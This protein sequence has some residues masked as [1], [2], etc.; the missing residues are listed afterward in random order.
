ME[1]RKIL[2]SLIV[3]AVYLLNGC[4]ALQPFPNYAK[5][6][7]TISLAVG[8]PIDMTRANTTA[9]FT[10]NVDEIPVDITANIRAI[11]KLYPDPTSKV[12]QATMYTNELVSSS[13]HAPWVTIVAIDLPEGLAVGSGEIQFNTTA[14]Y[15]DITSHI[16]NLQLPV[17]IIAGTGTPNSF[18][19]ELGIGS[20]TVSDLTNLES[21]AVAVFSPAIPSVACPCPDYAA[22]EIKATI[23]TSIGALNPYFTKIVA[24]DLTVSTISERNFT[25][26][27]NGEE[28]TAMFISTT[29]KLKYFEAQFS[30]AV[31]EAFSFLGLPTI[32]SV[33]YFDLDGNE[34]SGPVA[35]YSVSLK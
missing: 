34:I 23:P 31:H 8:S 13:N 18:V 4:T 22:I 21:Q 32:N 12:Y 10:S 17:E 29:G 24:E 28:V 7:D 1:I 9:T 6:G 25:H 2:T 35:D 3:L 20:S 27:T 19:H 14:I 11:F 30:V 15:P 16:N 33:R 26:G 5:G